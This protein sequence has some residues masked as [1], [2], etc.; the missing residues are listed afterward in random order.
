MQGFAALNEPALFDRVERLAFN[1]LPAALTADMW[2]HVYVQQAN[3]VFAGRT[4][5]TDGAT[6][7]DTPSGEDSGSNYYGVSH[8]PC[9]ITN[10]PQGWPKFAASAVMAAA[11]GSHAF[12]LASLVPVRAALPFGG[13]VQVEGNYPFGD[14]VQVR[15]VLPA[16]LRATAYVRIPGWADEAT[17]EGKPAPNGTLVAV[18]CV[19]T[20]TLLVALK[21]TVRTQ[22]GWG[23][24]S[25][26]ADPGRPPTNALTVSRGPLLFA[27][28][29]AERRRV[30]KTYDD[31]LPGRPLAV[32]C[33]ISNP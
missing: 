13:Y 18:P 27:L 21:P 5:P 15:V 12:V 24:V 20:S 11:D 16:S 19:G 2:T 22:A 31:A 6:M 3:S 14:A 23:V 10:F 29:P 32:G 33:G 1:A 9:C 30:V 7:G 28:H 26:P 8:F 25:D 4:A 17:I